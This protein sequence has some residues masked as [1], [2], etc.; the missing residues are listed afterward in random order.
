LNRFVNEPN[1]SL[2][3]DPA[4]LKALLAAREAEIDRLRQIIK[5]LQ[6]HRFGRRAESLPIDQ[7]LLGLEEADQVE[8]EDF[9][10]E[11]IID[12]A[13][14]EAHAR[15]RRANRGSLPAH[16]PRIEQI[17]DITDKACPCC[18]GPLHVMGEDASERLDVVPAQ[19]RV[20]VTRRPKYACRQCEEVVVQEPAPARLVEGGIPT[21]ATVAHVLVAKYADHLPLYR[22]SQ[23]Y[24]RQGVALDRSTLA[25]WVGKAAFLLRPVHERLFE[26]LKASGKLFADETTAPV[27]D[28]GRG[29]TKTGQLF[30]YARDDRPWGGADPPGVAYLYA[31][32]RKAEQPMR[33]L[34]SFVGI[35]QVDGY[36]GYKV[37][38]ERNAVSLAFCWSHVRRKFYELA[39]GGPAPIAAEALT[40]ITELY[41]IEGE[42][43]GRPTEERRAIRQQKSRAI[44]EALEVWLKAKLALV[45]Q[46]S[47]LAEAIRYALSRWVG[48]ARFL[49]DGRIEIDSNVVERS[50]RPIALNRKNALFAGSD[51]GGEHWAIIASLVETAKLN[52]VDPQAY[53]ANVIARI[54]AGHPQSQI[55]ELLPWAYA[56]APIKAV[57]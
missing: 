4:A 43:R 2:P 55:D 30:A 3:D 36:A 38:A 13:K 46:K 11:E 6:R 7:L 34:A 53:L 32:D 39:Q 1:T 45:S 50:I 44:V 56:P 12:A 18:R 20:I 57:A 28:P 26:R 37:L 40:R 25:D 9:A 52:D 8:A 29:R 48:L 54:V 42:I 27:L 23:I 14:R 41:K 19:F 49:D 24:A 35:L 10:R 51:G 22:Q 33:H 31:P 21:E 47:K 16:L 5:E 17:I 15:K